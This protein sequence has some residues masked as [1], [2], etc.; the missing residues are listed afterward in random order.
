MYL[1]V[2]NIII[3][4]YAFREHRFVTTLMMF[5]L[6]KQNYE[7]YINTGYIMN[8]IDRIFLFEIFPNIV[9]KKMLT[10]IIIKDINVNMHSVNEYIKL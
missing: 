6:T 2:I 9:I 10:L 7:L 3:K 5:V 8:L 4:E 1:N